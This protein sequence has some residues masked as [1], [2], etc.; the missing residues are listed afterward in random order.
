MEKDL[1]TKSY[2]SDPGRFADLINGVM[3]AGKEIVAPEE[4]HD[5]DSYTGTFYW[6]GVKDKKGSGQRYRDLVKKAAFGINFM[7][8]GIENQEEVHYLMPLRCMAYD[9]G[10][11]ERQAVKIRKKV[12]KQK[13]ISSAEFLS[14]FTKE[15]LLQP[16]VTIV[17]YYG[18]NWDGAR[19]LYSILD[20]TNIPEELKNVVNNYR[21][22]ICEVRK[23]INTDVFRTDLKQ[24]FDCIR[25]ADDKESL[26]ELIMKDP[27]Y[28]EL[29]EKAYDV[30]AEYVDADEFMDVKKCIQ[31]GET[32]NMGSAFKEIMQD[33]RK[34]GQIEAIIETSREFGAARED[35]VERLMRKVQLSEEEAKEYLEKY[36]P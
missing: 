28:K 3:C 12:R 16:C 25:F 23:F 36:W 9:V 26:Y 30:I 6:T 17:V 18:K 15:S 32:V 5:M 10:E 19:D 29:D 27:D 31:E 11:Y 14:G 13:G 7:V 20:F 24:V 2:L 34:E 33:A 4:L 22:H 21:I 8:I 35:T 1:K